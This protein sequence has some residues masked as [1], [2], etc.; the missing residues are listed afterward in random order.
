MESLLRLPPWPVVRARV[1][2]EIEALRTHL[3]GAPD[4][5]RMR[6]LQ[7]AS[8]ALEALLGEIEGAPKAT[9]QLQR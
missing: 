9:D 6:Q 7:G 4:V 1:A 2:R 8:Q 3:V 5:D